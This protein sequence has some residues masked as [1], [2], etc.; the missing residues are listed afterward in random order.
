M[1]DAT[2]ERENIPDDI[3][4]DDIRPSGPSKPRR[5]LVLG[6]AAA[7]PSAYTLAS[8]AQAAV[9]SNLRCW[10]ATPPA[11]LAPVSAIDDNWFR[12]K[13]YVGKQGSATAYCVMA[14]Q[15]SCIDPGNPAKGADGSVWMVNG[16]RMIAG[17]GVNITNVS[18]T[19]QAYGLV[20]VN[21]EGT[22]NTLDQNGSQTLQPVA[23]SCWNSLIG[24]RISNL[25]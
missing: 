14:N 13:V 3:T 24:G 21:Q 16:Q 4:P 10:S 19:P 23:D 5:R 2:G 1:A 7:L 18:S 22:I 12:A 6:A 9:A 8:G 15:S 20:Y 25:G 17:P 11:D